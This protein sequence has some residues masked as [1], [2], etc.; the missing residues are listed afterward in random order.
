MTGHRPETGARQNRESNTEFKFTNAL[1]VNAGSTLQT[2]DSSHSEPHS[3]I[4]ASR[5]STRAGE[6]RRVTVTLSEN[7]GILLTQ[8]SHKVSAPMNAMM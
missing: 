7:V 8:Q 4:E 1:D 6:C 3:T 5:R 2:G